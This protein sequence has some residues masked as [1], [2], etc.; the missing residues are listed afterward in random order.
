MSKLKTCFN[1]LN[2][3]NKGINDASNRVWNDWNEYKRR[4]NQLHDLWGDK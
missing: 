2:S 3:G 4:D 1:Y